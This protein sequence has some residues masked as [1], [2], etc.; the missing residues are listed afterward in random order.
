M[1]EEG[2]IVSIYE[3]IAEI[4]IPKG[5]ACNRCGLCSING[6]K[7]LIKLKL[8]NEH[9]KQGQT[10]KLIF[11]SKKLLSLAFLVYIIPVFALVLG[12][13]VGKA[14]FYNEKIGIIFS[15]CFMLFSLYIISLINKKK[16]RN[17][18]ITVEKL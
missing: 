15:F 3:G 2:R 1:E 17:F 16:L 6:D 4:E 14:L 5:P 9:F 13:I 11:S 12:Y 18:Q 7:S 10:V 8:P